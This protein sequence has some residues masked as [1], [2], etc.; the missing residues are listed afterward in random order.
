MCKNKTPDDRDNADETDVESK[1]N[2]REDEMK[3]AIAIQNE[4]AVKNSI[5]INYHQVF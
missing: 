5:K 1:N 4:E 2:D 3:F